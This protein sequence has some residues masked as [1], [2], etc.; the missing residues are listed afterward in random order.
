MQRTLDWSKAPGAPI[1]RLAMDVNPLQPAAY[2]ASPA[3]AVPPPRAVPP[4]V[5]EPSELAA[6]AAGP[7]EDGPRPDALAAVQ[8]AAEAYEVLRSKQRELRFEPTDEGI[9]RISIFDGTGRLLGTIPP[10]EALAL[11]SGEASWQA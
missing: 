5:E 3:T 4:R 6:T 2:P 11:A 7:R 8:V 9:L 1:P 10:T